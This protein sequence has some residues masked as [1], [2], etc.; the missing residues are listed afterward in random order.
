MCTTTHIL[1]A[2]KVFLQ[3]RRYTFRHDTVFHRII[4]SLR[5]FILNIKQAVPTSPKSSMK[6]AK[7][8][9]KVDTLHQTSAWVPLADLGS[10]Y[11]FPIHLAFTQLRPDIT[12]FSS[13]LRKVKLIEL[14]CT[15][16]ENMGSWHSAKINKYLALKTTTKSNEWSVEPFVVKVSARRYCSNLFRVASKN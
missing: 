16:E 11:C 1:G 10:N 14:T 4:E 9:T 13:A 6:F 5:S 12:I 8:R 15:C 2:S 3:Q 7:K